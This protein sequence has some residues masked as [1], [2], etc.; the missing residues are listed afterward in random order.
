MRWNILAIFLVLALTMSACG[1]QTNTP[2]D[3][4]NVEVQE[5]SNTEV[6]ENNVVVEEWEDWD[7][8]YENSWDDD[9]S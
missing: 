7:E 3:T 8:E 5:E 9:W 4:T 6:Q 1:N 2:P